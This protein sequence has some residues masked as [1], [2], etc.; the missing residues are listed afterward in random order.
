MIKKRKM[1]ALI[2]LMVAMCLNVQFVNAQSVAEGNYG[3][4]AYRLM[5]N[6]YANY[7]QASFAYFSDGYNQM[8]VGVTFT[9]RVAGGNNY[10][11]ESAGASTNENYVYVTAETRRLGTVI[12]VST[13]AIGYINDTIVASATDYK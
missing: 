9:H 6:C 5:V 4:G 7:G 13:G 10:I 1:F 3:N 12:P 8:R 2:L 11:Y